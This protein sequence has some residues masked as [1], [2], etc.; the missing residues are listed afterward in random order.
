GGTI[1]I[2]SGTVQS[3]VSDGFALD[4]SDA[5]K[6]NITGGIVKS[7]GSCSDAIHVDAASLNITGGN[8]SATGNAIDNSGSTVVISGGTV[9]GTEHFIFN[10]K[11]CSNDTCFN[12]YRDGT[13]T[14]YKIDGNSTK[15][16]SLKVDSNITTANEGS[17]TGLSVVGQSGEVTYSWAYENDVS[18]ILYKIG[19]SDESFIAVPGVTVKPN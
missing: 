5:G 15:Y 3:T 4:V 1:N 16:L 17:T 9:S 11:Y 18:G 6:I 2:S 8:V 12:V 7:T 10:S 19:D 14:N 13:A